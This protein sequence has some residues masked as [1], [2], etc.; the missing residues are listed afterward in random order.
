MKKSLWLKVLIPFLAIVILVV[1][2]YFTFVFH[3]NCNDL[4]CFK[5]KQARC[6]KTQ[7]LY[8]TPETAWFYSIEGKTKY[9]GTSACEIEV[10]AVQIKGGDL[11]RQSLEGE[12]MTCYLP[13]GL[14]ALPESDLS[15]CHGLLKEES[16]DLI[17]RRLHSY[18]IENIGEVSEELVRI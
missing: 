18:I 10:K 14:T 8:D 15:R 9:R 2:L 5:S 1:A 7:F 11:D 4:Q 17:I 6:V 12:T 16:Q 13:V 3:Y